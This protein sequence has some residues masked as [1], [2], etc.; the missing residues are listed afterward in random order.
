MRCKR[1][2]Y[3]NEYDYPFSLADGSKHITGR[4]TLTRDMVNEEDGCNTTK[5]NDEEE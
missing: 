1:C 5:P 2:K 3:Y 4:C